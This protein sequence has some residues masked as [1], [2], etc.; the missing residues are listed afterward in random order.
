M[1]CLVNM[2]NGMNWVTFVSNASNYTK[3]YGFSP[4]LVDMFALIYMI[5]YPFVCFPQSYII[6]NVSLRWGVII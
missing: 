6:D 5:T 3:Y 2:G 1:F 4:L